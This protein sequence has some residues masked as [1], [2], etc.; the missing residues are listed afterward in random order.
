MMMGDETLLGAIPMEDLDLVIHPLTQEI[1]V[2]PESPDMPS[3][4]AKQLFPK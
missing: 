4:L 1:T 3:S 2:N